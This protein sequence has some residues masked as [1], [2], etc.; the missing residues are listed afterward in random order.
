MLRYEPDLYPYLHRLD[1]LHFIQPNRG[2]GLFNIVE[3][4]KHELDSPPDKRSFF[5]LKKYVYITDEGR[6]YLKALN[7]LLK[8]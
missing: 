4:H 2:Y 8:K 1:G 7:D 3:D 5:D 6:S